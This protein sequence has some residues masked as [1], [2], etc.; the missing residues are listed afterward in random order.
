MILF[1]G[2]AFLFFV[3]LAA[4]IM[5]WQ[6]NHVLHDVASAWIPA[7]TMGMMGFGLAVLVAELLGWRA[8]KGQPAL[9]ALLVLSLPA[10]PLVGLLA[11]I[12]SLLQL[13]TGDHRQ[14]WRTALSVGALMSLN[15]LLPLAVAGLWVGGSPGLLAG[16]SAIKVQFFL[17]VDYFL[18]RAILHYFSSGASAFVSLR[19]LRK[20]TVS[21]LAVVAIMLGVWNLIVVNSVMTGFQT[22]FREQMRGSLSHVLV[23]FRSEDVHLR[24]PAEGLRQAEWADYVKRIE[25]SDEML[26]PWQA[27]LENAVAL[28]R[29]ADKDA[30][31][32]PRDFAGQP[33]LPPDDET[34]PR[35][36]EQ[37]DQPGLSEDERAFL[38]RLKSGVGL[39]DF[40][41]ECLRDGERIITPRDFYLARVGDP[42]KAEDEIHRTWYA[43]LFRDALQ[44]EFDAAERALRDHRNA[45]GQ[46][47][48]DGVSWRVSTKTFITPKTGSRELPIAELVGV[49]VT[50]EP[51]ISRL[52]EYVANAERTDFR[53]QYVLG[54]L[55]NILGATLGW[56]TEES[57][58]ATEAQRDFMFTEDGKGTGRFPS[59]MTRTLALRRFTTATGRVI[60]REFDNVR[61]LEFSPG[62]RIYERVREAY[63]DASRTEDLKQLGKIMK[64]CE[65]D[66]RAILQAELQHE[67]ASERWQQV[68]YTGALIIWNDYLTGINDSVDAVRMHFGENITLLKEFVSEAESRGSLPG[69]VA[70]ANETWLKLKEASEAAEKLAK[71]RDIT[72]A[73]REAALLALAARYQEIYDGA[74]KQAE[75]KGY[76]GIL[77]LLQNLRAYAGNPEDLLPLRKR[78]D[79]RL[80][81]PLAYAAEN[82]DAQAEAVAA[83]MQAY[84]EVLPLRTSMRAGETV[85]DY[86]QR[87]TTP[88]TRPDPDKPG[89]I[90]GD[91]LAESALGA[92]VNV[93]DSIAVTIPR[94]YYEDN[95]LVPRTVEVWFKVTGFFRSGLYDENRGRMY[96][97]FEELTNLL[98]DSEVR[99]VVGARLKDYRPYQGQLESEKLKAELRQS[100]KMHRAHYASVGV[101]E[102]ETRTLL[103]AVNIERSLIQLIVSFIIV[104]AGGAILMIVYQLVN[105]KVKDIGILKALGHS[106]WGIRSVF[107]F[108]ALF[109]GLFGALLGCAVG[110]IFSEYLN[111][112]EDF[113]DE[114]TGIRLFPPDVYFLTYIPSVK[115]WDLLL[116]ATDIAVPVIMFGFFCGILPSMAAARKDP[117]EALHYE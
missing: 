89:I 15:V 91:A 69:E 20:R 5:A 27:A 58:A 72:E 82:F 108:N 33:P 80:K 81:V 8:T 62:R 68:N 4:A 44:Q 97:D 85:E 11:G 84:R 34:G 23:R 42:K 41:R 38:Q 48:V 14:I 50:R 73:E 61:Y 87:A 106:P 65:S 66:V 70:L 111:Q 105:E 90:L 71:S 37:P 2:L 51:A 26:L 24:L 104:L 74:I 52:G 110:M 78:M 98:A 9:N 17:V 39:S 83:R 112:I 77:D 102:D 47:D 107:M 22:D 96:C 29:A 57:V 31:P 18:C 12:V 32:D 19:F 116:L 86:R 46:P 1:R 63:K 113:I 75:E 36:T 3:L 76:G 99:Y 59:D 55:L 49:D 16:W 30:L 25:A 109:I 60:W 92:G 88:G 21:L 45:V 40:D 93:G 13:R 7:A 10:V 101:W 28:Y 43:P 64:A 95:R 67:G 114:S 117:V 53:E 103:E 79:L 35:D 100:L 6:A 56:E 54:P 94:I 115:G